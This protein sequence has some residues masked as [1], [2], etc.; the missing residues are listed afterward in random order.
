MLHPK[1]LTASTG[2]VSLQTLHDTQHKYSYVSVNFYVLVSA[3]AIC[4]CLY[5]NVSNIETPEK[6]SI[7]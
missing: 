3:K 1:F 6:K 7:K 4:F 2:K 5:D